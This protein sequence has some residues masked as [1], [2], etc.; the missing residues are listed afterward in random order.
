MDAD[1]VDLEDYPEPDRAKMVLR[2][3]RE[4]EEAIEAWPIPEDE[5][6]VDDTPIS[7]IYRYLVRNRMMDDFT[8]FTSFGV[9]AIWR[10]VDPIMAAERRRGP[11]PKS[12]SMD[13]L[14]SYLSWAKTG[15]HQALLGKTFAMTETRFEDNLNRVR[16]PLRQ[17]LEEKWWSRRPRPKIDDTSTYPAVGLIVDGHTTEI[18]VPKTTFVQAKQWF[19]GHHHVYGYK[20]EIAVHGSSPHYCMF[21]SPHV[22]GAKHDYELHKDWFVNYAD[23]LR[24]TPQEAAQMPVA[25]RGEYW[26]VMGDKAYVGPAEDTAPIKRIFPRRGQLLDAR[27]EQD[28]R[29]INRRR[30]LV[31]QFLG[32]MLRLWAFLRGTWR[33]D[34]SHFDDD[35][36]IACLLTNEDIANHYLMEED[37][38]FYEKWISKRRNQSVERER[39][40]RANVKKSKERTKLRF[41]DLYPAA[42]AVQRRIDHE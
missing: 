25:W 3:A 40:Q 34:E 4:D 19:D 13:H 28:N 32:R 11:I 6:D 7:P 35:I 36:T 38:D 29:A 5:I 26:P 1:I 8:N 2:R 9:E 33:W 27:E 21:I 42:R 23:Y 41:A 15:Q 18:C 37:Q 39:K 30:V 20:N 14:L 17:A 12:S 16:A 31:E 22:P 24:M 10:L